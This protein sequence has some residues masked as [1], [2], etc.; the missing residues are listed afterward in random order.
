LFLFA[1]LPFQEQLDFESVRLADLDNRQTYSEVNMA[2]WWWDMHD[3]LPARVTVA[4][5]ICTSDM[6]HLTNCSSHQHAWQLYLTIGNIQTDIHRTPNKHARILIGLLTGPPEGANNCDKA[7][8]SAV[9]TVLSP[10]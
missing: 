8:Y 2:E 9:G 5:V 6:T 1:H 4:A 10:L 7:W 3:Q